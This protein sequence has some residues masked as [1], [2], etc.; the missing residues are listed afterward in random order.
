MWKEIPRL[1]LLLVVIAL[2]GCITTTAPPLPKA[3]LSEPGWTVQQGQAV[4]HRTPDRSSSGA[5]AGPSDI[6]G[7]LILA[8]RTD[9]ST[10]IQFSKAVPLFIAQS[11]PAGWQIEIP[12]QNRRYA[13]HGKPPRRVIWF[14]LA[15]ALAGK[16]L[17]KD[18]TWNNSGTN[19]RLVNRSSGESLEG[20]LTQ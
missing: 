12:P 19:W 1:W 14:Q 17:A 2:T 3:N 18:W 15:D 5:S 6:A 13:R 4:W 11:T 7:D 8:T 20:F 16:P 9:G 10:F